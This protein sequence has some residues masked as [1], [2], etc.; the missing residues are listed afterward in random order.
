MKKNIIRTLSALALVA[1]TASCNKQ[2]SKMDELPAGADSLSLNIKVAY[3]NVDSLQNNYELYTV[4]S[5]SLLGMEVRRQ[6]R[7]NDLASRLDNER[8][9]IEEKLKNNRYFSEEE[10]NRDQRNF[11]AMQKN[12][13]QEIANLNA[14][15]EEKAKELQQILKDSVDNFLAEYNKTKQYDMILRNEVVLYTLPK[16][17][18]TQDVINGLNKRYKK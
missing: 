1:L 16:Y 8:R 18:I 13:E 9:R 11:A 15:M 5:D 4:I 14:A 10:F 2:A 3:V 7:V 17:D 12:S 6:K